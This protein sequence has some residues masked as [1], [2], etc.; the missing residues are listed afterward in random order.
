MKKLLGVMAVMTFFL[1][2][3]G[4][5]VA[6]EPAKAEV[7]KL[8]AVG[9]QMKDFTLPSLGG[10]ELSFNKDIKGK[11]DLAVLVIM[12]TACTMCQMEIASVNDMM[13]KY[14]AKMDLYAVSVDIK[15][16]ETLKPYAEAYKYNATYLLDSKFSV[17]KMFGFRFTPAAIILDKSGKVVYLKGGKRGLGE[18]TPLEEKIASL[19]K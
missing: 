7:E 19:L 6:E 14:G 9:N 4:V 2:M 10:A 17:G 15:G 12:T 16:E 18:E 3:A 11:K 5:A 8:L 1:G 13:S